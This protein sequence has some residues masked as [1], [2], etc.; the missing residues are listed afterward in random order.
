MACIRILLRAFHTWLFQFQAVGIL[1]FRSESYNRAHFNLWILTCSTW[2][3]TGTSTLSFRTHRCLRSVNIFHEYSMSIFEIQIKIN[4]YYA[5]EPFLTNWK[6]QIL[7]H[8]RLFYLILNF[9]FTKSSSQNLFNFFNDHDTIFSYHLLNK[10][11][12]IMNSHYA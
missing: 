1:L 4:F 10:Y 11:V 3:R 2:G 9:T 6:W 7:F 5:H 8:F 12:S